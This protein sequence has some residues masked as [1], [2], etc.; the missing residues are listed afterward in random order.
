MNCVNGEWQ[1]K[2]PTCNTGKKAFSTGQITGDRQ[3]LATFRWN[4][5]TD[6]RVSY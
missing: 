1:W 2:I 4:E 5:G 6:T 3:Q